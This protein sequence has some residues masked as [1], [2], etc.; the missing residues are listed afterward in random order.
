VVDVADVL[1]LS[2][3]VSGRRLMALVGH[4]V[5]GSP[6]VARRA[7][8]VTRAAM[9][10]SCARMVAVAALAWQVEVSAHSA[11][12]R[13]NDAVAARTSQAELAA[14]FPEGRCA[15]GP[16]FRSAM[17][18][19]MIAWRRWSASGGEHRQR[20]VGEHRGAP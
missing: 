1:G 11:R 10:I 2:T 14:N 13:L 15:S 16:F 18:C 6:S 9:L 7:E 12:L 20:R 5:A 8:R 3:V 19:S 4:A 17:T